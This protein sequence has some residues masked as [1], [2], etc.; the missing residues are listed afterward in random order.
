MENVVAM[1]QE[2]PWVLWYVVGFVLLLIWFFRV[3][4]SVHGQ[5]I[6]YRRARR[7]E[8]SHTRQ[9]LDARTLWA[10][11]PYDEAQIERQLKRTAPNEST[12]APA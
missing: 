7:Y 8:I 12:E 10:L 9:P 2:H 1:H 6:R 5:R 11:S 4:R 3:V